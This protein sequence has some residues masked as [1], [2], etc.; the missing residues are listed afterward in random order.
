MVSA[1]AAMSTSACPTPTVSTSTTSKPVDSRTRTA[2]GVDAAMPPSCPRDAIDL[3][4][5]SV[6]GGVRLHANAIAEQRATGERR[7]RI[8]RKHTNS[9]LA[10]THRCNQRGRRGRL[11]HARRTSKPDDVGAFERRA[12]SSAD[13]SAGS[14]GS[15]S[16]TIE[17]SFPSACAVHQLDQSS[18]V[19]RT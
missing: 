15:S 19:R 3:M 2:C 5:T 1:I 17:S 12:P 14:A 10:F 4:K 11:P 8:D 16:S 13:M 7:R 6:I 9:L 18:T